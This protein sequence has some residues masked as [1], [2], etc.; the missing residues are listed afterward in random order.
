MMMFFKV[1]VF[2]FR[3][4]NWRD[5]YTN[6]VGFGDQSSWRDFRFCYKSKYDLK[7]SDHQTEKFSCILTKKLK[8]IVFWCCWNSSILSGLWENTDFFKRRGV[9]SKHEVVK[10]FSF[11]LGGRKE[12]FKWGIDNDSP[13]AALMLNL[14]KW[15]IVDFEDLMGIRRLL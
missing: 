14:E 3:E 7:E 5:F 15:T 2:D 13:E 12:V 11:S 10:I 1:L 8:I 9:I 4:Y 6:S